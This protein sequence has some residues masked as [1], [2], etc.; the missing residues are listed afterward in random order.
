MVI[1][2]GEKLIKAL[3]ELEQAQLDGIPRITRRDPN[4]IYLTKSM[5]KEMLTYFDMYP[6][7]IEVGFPTDELQETLD[8]FHRP[9]VYPH[10]KSPGGSRYFQFEGQVI[11][12]QP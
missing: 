7:D 8:N 1:Q 5:L 9:K 10:L 3:K 4:Q 12:G 6:D 2:T 11:K